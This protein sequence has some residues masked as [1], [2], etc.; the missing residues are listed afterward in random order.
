MT[1]PQKTP[2]TIQLDL[3]PEHTL[4]LVL[5]YISRHCREET[6]SLVED[7]LFERPMITSDELAGIAMINEAIN[8]TIGLIIERHNDVTDW[9][10]FIE[11]CN[12][13]CRIYVVPS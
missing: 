5:D 13:P 8:D 4:T 7:T 3:T 11:Y 12:T 2:D 9:D 10:S 1:T 6:R